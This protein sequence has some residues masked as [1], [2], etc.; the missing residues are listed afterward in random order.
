MGGPTDLEQQLLK[1]FNDARLDPMGDAARFIASY[2]PLTSTYS[3]IQAAF[4]NFNV[5]GAAV[6]SAIQALTSV[7]QVAWNDNLATSAL[8]HDNAMIAADQQSHQLPGEASLNSR[9]AT[10]GYINFTNL[11]E[12]IFA[13]ATSSMDAHA[14]FMVDW[15]PGPNGMVS[16]PDH[17][18][19]IMNATYREIGVGIVLDSNPSTVVGPLV[20][21][22]EFGT[23]ANS[24][25][26]S[27]GAAYND[28][29]HN[30]FYS[31]GEGLGNLTVALGAANVTS[32]AS[33]GYTLQ[34]VAT[35]NQTI[36][37]S[38]AGLTGAATVAVNLAANSNIKLDVVDGNSLHTSTS[39]VVSGPISEIVGLGT[40]GLRLQAVGSSAHTVIGAKGNDTLVGDTGAD[41]LIGGIGNDTLTGAGGEEVLTG[42]AGRAPFPGQCVCELS[43][44]GDH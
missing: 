25:V 43:A 8:N 31:A 30:H 41:T 32:F 38:G 10:A 5:Q 36:T 6:Q 23:R 44:G 35:G 20:V 34:T 40:I 28:T 9:T 21:T 39:A 15:G 33:G 19:T 26:F 4:V 42:G 2:S 16:V 1:L 7:E 17:R 14:A 13:F 27:L 12:N 3:D 37:L 18:N 11:A 22:E 24:G 29:D